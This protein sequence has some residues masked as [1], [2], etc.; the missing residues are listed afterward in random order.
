MTSNPTNP[1]ACRHKEPLPPVTHKCTI[2]MRHASLAA[3]CLRMAF[4]ERPLS[5]RNAVVVMVK[6]D[7]R[8]RLMSS[9]DEAAASPAGG[10]GR[11]S[12]GR[13]CVRV[14]VCWRRGGGVS[15]TR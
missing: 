9:V 5:H 11:G 7:V 4:S 13:G 15:G 3:R 6:H 1:R 14:C 12:G 2:S 10:W 8:R